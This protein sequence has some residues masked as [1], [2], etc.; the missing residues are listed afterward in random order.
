ME[1]HII[2]LSIPKNKL[3]GWQE[4]GMNVR[5]SPWDSHSTCRGHRWLRYDQRDQMIVLV[6]ALLLHSGVVFG[7]VPLFLFPCW[8]N[9]NWN[10]NGRICEN[11]KKLDGQLLTHLARRRFSSSSNE[12]G[13]IKM[14][15]ASRE[16]ALTDLAPWTSMSRMHLYIEAKS[17]ISNFSKIKRISISVMNILLGKARRIFWVQRSIDTIVAVWFLGMVF[18]KRNGLNQEVIK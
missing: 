13:Q 8:Q 10:Q 3:L 11:E 12:G 2:R 1:S 5:W 6:Q 4:K 18:C 9:S 16:L 14:K 17:S 15:M 7:S